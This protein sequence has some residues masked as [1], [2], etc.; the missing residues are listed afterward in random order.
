[1]QIDDKIF[2]WETLESR[3]IYVGR[4]K[5]DSCLMVLFKRQ[6]IRT[7]SAPFVSP[8]SVG[9]MFDDRCVKRFEKLGD[10][11]VALYSAVGPS[12]ARAIMCLF[13]HFMPLG[14]Q[15]GNRE[16]PPLQDARDWSF[17]H[18]VFSLNRQCE[19]GISR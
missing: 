5:V 12:Y 9:R 4:D 2:H 13:V 7:V 18:F 14:A 10:R 11:L 16:R 17:S 8:P 19:T 15:K 3:Q 1:L 6:I